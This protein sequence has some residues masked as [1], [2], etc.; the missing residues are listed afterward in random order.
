VLIYTSVIGVIL[1]PLRRCRKGVLKV[2]FKRYCIAPRQKVLNRCKLKVYYKK[3]CVTPRPK[4]DSTGYTAIGQSG[5]SQLFSLRNFFLQ[6][7]ISFTTD[8]TGRKL[9]W[10]LKK[11]SAFATYDLYLFYVIE[12]LNNENIPS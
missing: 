5:R 6:K 9:K 8:S 12:W 2:Y 4:T 7:S 1:H 10:L 3:C 11:V